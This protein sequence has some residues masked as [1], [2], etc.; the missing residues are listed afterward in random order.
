MLGD[1]WNKLLHP[2]DQPRA[3][4]VWRDAVE[5]RTSYDL[6][7]RVRR[8]D[9]AYE[10][11]RVIGR[12]IRDANGRI[13]RWFGVA[14]NIEALKR[15]E[16]ALRQRAEEIERL[17]D[18]VPVA[19]WVA[20]DPECK[21]ITGNRMA[22]EFYEAG[23]DENVSATTVPDARAFFDAEGRALAAEELPMQAAAARN[24]DVHDV[25]LQARMPS[26]RRIAML[27]S[28]TPLRDEKGN[29][30]GCIGAFLDIPSRKEF[31]EQLRRT[32]EEL[33]RS[34]RD[35][36]QFAY[37]ASHDLQEPLRMVSNFVDLLQRRG[38][39]RIPEELVQFMT[40]VSDGVVRMQELIKGL[41]EYSRGGRNVTTKCSDTKKILEQVLQDSS[42]QIAET[43]AN[44]TQGELPSVC[45][46]PVQ[47][48]QIFRNLI[49]NAIKFRKPGVPPRIEV[50]GA[51]CSASADQ[52]GRAKLD[53]PCTRP[54]MVIFSVS[55][56]GI[57][58]A[59]EF[60]DRIFTIFQRLHTRKEYPGTGIGLAI[61]KKIVE[62]HGGRIWV[63]SEPGK[64]STFFFTL[65]E[66]GARAIST[67]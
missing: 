55:D 5:G 37:V 35:L 17:M 57:G 24:E 64:G 47:L 9:G 65:P 21:I 67:S 58:I 10:W 62:G 30:R 16:E 53:G 1:G 13:V 29:A 66:D 43:G 8:K 60:R 2:E 34:N 26:G 19:V 44:I 20:H 46:D 31:E 61:C 50:S 45:V 49:G 56:N 7:Y 39:G 59:P 41:L 12:P 54:E 11:F 48:G 52:R 38:E 32:A 18:I 22:N 25:E 14:V 4:A 27:G 15:A 33:R 6:E 63:E 3:Y 40:Y 51:R 36:E 28:A 23:L 42:I